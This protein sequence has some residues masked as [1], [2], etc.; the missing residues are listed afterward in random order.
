MWNVTLSSFLC[1]TGTKDVL[2]IALRL[3]ITK[4][5]LEEKEGFIIMDDPLIDLD[6]NRQS[7]AADVIK[8]F[9]ENKQL[10]LLTYHPAHAKMLGGNQIELSNYNLSQKKRS[11]IIM[12][13]S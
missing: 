6:P 12:Q 13:P 3:A 8:D 1:S 10:I 4:R 2:G 5:F 7:K 11:S 9:A